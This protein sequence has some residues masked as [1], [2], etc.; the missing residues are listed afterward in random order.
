MSVYSFSDW[1]GFASFGSVAN[2]TLL[3]GRLKAQQIQL[4]IDFGGVSF[5]ASGVGNDS[6]RLGQVEDTGEQT[7]EL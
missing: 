7:R 4:A 5:A 6:C 3:V 2:P 1:M